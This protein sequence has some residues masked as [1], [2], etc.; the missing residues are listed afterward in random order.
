MWRVVVQA[1]KRYKKGENLIFPQFWLL[2]FVGEK[3]E[4]REK[5]KGFFFFLKSRANLWSD[6]FGPI[7]KVHLLDESYIYILKIGDFDE[8]SKIGFLEIKV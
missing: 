8:V 3:G 2:N 5:I 7:T 6:Y 1:S 4:K